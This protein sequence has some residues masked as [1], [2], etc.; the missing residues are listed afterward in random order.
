MKKTFAI[1]V[2]VTTLTACNARQITTVVDHAG[3]VVDCL[4]L[5]KKCAD[6]INS[7]EEPEKILA[8]G[9]Q[10]YDETERTHCTDIIRD[11]EGLQ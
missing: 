9:L 1:L 6:I 3:L 8:A 10:C 11:Y 2:I 7:E 5:I 4:E